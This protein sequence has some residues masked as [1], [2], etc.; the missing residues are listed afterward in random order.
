MT[1]NNAL[2]RLLEHGP[3]TFGQLV[4]ITGWKVSQVRG[5]VSNLMADGTVQAEGEKMKMVYSLTGEDFG[6]GAV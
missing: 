5:A 3:L 1:R 2:K 4:D 6:S